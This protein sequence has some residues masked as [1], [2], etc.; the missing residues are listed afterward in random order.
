MRP[1]GL[2]KIVCAITGSGALAVA[3]CGGPAPL[4]DIDSSRPDTGVTPGD[5]GRDTG[6]PTADAGI[7]GGSDT[8]VVADSGVDA[9]APD[10][11]AA[12]MARTLQS[13]GSAVV[14]TADDAALRSASGATKGRD[15][16]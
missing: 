14:L 11:G 1:T 5:G 13:N 16:R 4:P 10:A 6:T 12:L 3:G 9:P 7:D 2:L 15:S 8:G